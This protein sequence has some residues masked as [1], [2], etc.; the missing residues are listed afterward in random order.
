MPSPLLEKRWRKL[1][2]MGDS[3]IN[4]RFHSAVGKISCTYDKFT[5][6][7]ESSESVE[8]MIHSSSS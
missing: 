5:Y 4:R 1:L 3:W 7:L 8:S 2:E 6:T